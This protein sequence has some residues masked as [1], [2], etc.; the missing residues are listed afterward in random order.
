MSA[1]KS[2]LFKSIWRDEGTTKLEIKN[3]SSRM[4]HLLET[5]RFN[6][7]RFSSNDDS[8]LLIGD[9]LAESMI[10]SVSRPA[11]RSCIK[12]SNAEVRLGDGSSSMMAEQSLGELKL[13]LSIPGGDCTAVFFLRCI[14]LVGEAYLVCIMPLEYVD[15]YQI[16]KFVRTFRIWNDSRNS[17]S[18]RFCNRFWLLLVCNI[19]TSS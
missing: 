16:G 11:N 1:F 3:F 17:T 19:T 7:F 13:K 9:D 6:E 12:L 5:D 4:A 10:N 8:Q 15:Q 2:A 18:S 14:F